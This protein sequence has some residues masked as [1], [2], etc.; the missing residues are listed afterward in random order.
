MT[1]TIEFDQE[2]TFLARTYAH[3]LAAVVAF[4]LFE[5]ALFRTGLADPIARAFLSVNWLFVLG[6][7]ILT[8]WLFRRLAYSVTSRPSQYIGLAGYVVVEGLIFVPLLFQAERC[9][10]GVIQVAATITLL[11]FGSLSYVVFRT[12]HDFSFLEPFLNW[13]GLMALVLI[14]AACLF[15]LHLGLWFSLA[16]IVVAGA[17]ILHDTSRILFYFSDD[18]YAAAALELF[19]SVALLFW[20]VVDAMGGWW[21]D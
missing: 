3:L 21:S 15:G 9:F 13:A 17:S 10:P 2:A 20:Y 19:A 12:R 6:G 11:G 5:V 14:V 1:P 8:A 16:M 4:V 7:F 18:Q